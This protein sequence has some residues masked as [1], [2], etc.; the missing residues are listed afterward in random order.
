MSEQVSDTYTSGII[1]EKITT[2]EFER[3]KCLWESRV[4]I[5]ENTEYAVVRNPIAHRAT[6][7]DL[8]TDYGLLISYLLNHPL[9]DEIDVRKQ[10][11]PYP[12]DERVKWIQ[13]FKR[14]AWGDIDLLAQNAADDTRKMNYLEIKFR[15][16]DGSEVLSSKRTTMEFTQ[17]GEMIVGHD[18]LLYPGH[19]RRL[20]SFKGDFS[21]K[22]YIHGFADR[23]LIFRGG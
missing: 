17:I 20:F 10:H 5:R 7:S 4:R 3:L 2:D 18:I 21:D 9:V 19:N 1:L 6:S 14:H 8:V 16:D 11:S 15:E 22:S 23:S 12:K 13:R